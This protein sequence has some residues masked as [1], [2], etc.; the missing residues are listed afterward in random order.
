MYKIS[1][2]ANVLS[3]PPH[4]LRYYETEG[5]IIPERNPQGERLYNEAHLEWL[6]FIIK[7]RETRMPISVIKQ[8]VKL[9]K[10][11][12]HTTLERLRLLEDHKASIQKQKVELEEM[13]RMIEKKVNVYKTMIEIE[14]LTK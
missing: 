1:E 9:V 14:Q 7:L 5:I 6:R 12:E 2:A 8:Y 11:G 13:E 3:I 4:T 10:Q